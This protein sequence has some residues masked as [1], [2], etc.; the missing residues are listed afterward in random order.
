MSGPR[1]AARQAALQ[2]L[3]FWQVGG[4]SP[5]DALTA[6]F[7]EHEPDAPDAVRAFAAE[8]VHGT[9]GDVAALDRVIEQHSKNWRLERLATIDRLILRLA[10]WELMHQTDTPPAVVI[11]EAI[12]LARAFS[13]EEAAK[14]VN[15]VLDAIKK[16]L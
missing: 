8:L 6:F 14:F 9:V 3:Y 10:A 15:G 7:A 12:E 16:A 1:H 11:N 4:A 2:V 13:G 5:E